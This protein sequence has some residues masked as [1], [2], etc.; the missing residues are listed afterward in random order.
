MLAGNAI[1]IAHLDETKMENGESACRLLVYD[2]N[3]FDYR[4]IQKLVYYKFTDVLQNADGQ[5]KQFNDKASISINKVQDG[6]YAIDCSK[7]TDS[8]I[9][10]S[11]GKDIIVTNEEQCK[12]TVGDNVF[13][14][15]SE[16]DKK[17]PQTE[18]DELFSQI[19]RWKDR[20]PTILNAKDVEIKIIQKALDQSKKGEKGEIGEL[21]TDLFFLRHGW[22][23]IDVKL[24]GADRKDGSEGE[25]NR[26]F[27]GV[28]VD[29]KDEPTYMFITESKLQERSVGEKEMQSMLGV[30]AVKNKMEGV[31]KDHDISKWYK[32]LDGYA[33][34]QSTMF[35]GYCSTTYKRQWM[36]N[37]VST[38]TDIAPPIHVETQTDIAEAVSPNV[39]TQTDISAA[40][41]TIFQLVP[42]L[43]SDK[44]QS[45]LAAMLATKDQD[46]RTIGKEYKEYKAKQ[47]EVDELASKLAKTELTHDQAVL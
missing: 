9:W 27:D 25:G 3:H 33:V 6:K 31:Y 40:L 18:K 20:A 32:E 2:L 45:L 30:D 4:K 8:N 22:K 36:R 5:V 7:M 23:K 43:T 34:G 46:I 37:H 38:Q 11:V 19:Y 29:N 44:F 13:Y 39:A 10:V 42:N 41:Q 14:C 21:I 1:V 47:A 15:A 12:F 17:L 16:K 24:K 26:G 28:F 35:H